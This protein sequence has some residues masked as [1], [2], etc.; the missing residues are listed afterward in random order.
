[1]CC[2]V[3]KRTEA[4]RRIQ[5]AERSLLQLRNI[6]VKTLRDE[7]FINKGHLYWI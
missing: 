6:T 1:M 4:E 3:N 5:M 7:N 2:Q